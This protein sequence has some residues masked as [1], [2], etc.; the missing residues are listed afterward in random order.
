MGEVST[1]VVGKLLD[2]GSQSIFI[3]ITCRYSQ[4]GFLG[5]GRR[6]V[7]FFL[8]FDVRLAVHKRH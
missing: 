4:A 5:I 7:V 1:L 8:F 3:I 6:P 2:Q